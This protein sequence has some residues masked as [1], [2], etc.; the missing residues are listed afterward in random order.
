LKLNNMDTNFSV[1]STTV[2][3]VSNFLQ[4][5]KK[6]FPNINFIFSQSIDYEIGFGN[7]KNW[8]ISNDIYNNIDVTPALLWN[9]EPLRVAEPLLDKGRKTSYKIHDGI[10][11]ADILAY[12]APNLEI[13][14]A[15]ITNS[16]QELELIEAVYTCAMQD[17]ISMKIDYPVFGEFSY[18]VDFKELD[19]L[20]I[21]KEGSSYYL[22]ASSATIQGAI[23]VLIDK[24][25][26]LKNIITRTYLDLYPSTFKIEE[27]NHI[28]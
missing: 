15:F 5:Y 16:L 24:Y 8:K 6:Y 23:F 27:V 20:T 4:L 2:I 26:L 9:R 7:R 12:A 13:K 18:T 11:H 28:V 3:V 22:L 1:I 25:P 10:D 17:V 21:N 14:F 19:E